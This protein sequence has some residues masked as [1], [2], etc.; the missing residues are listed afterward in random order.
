MPDSVLVMKFGGTSVGSPESID[1]AA[2]L[3]REQARTVQGRCRRVRDV[4][5]D[6]TS[7]WPRLT[8]GARGEHSAVESNLSKLKGEALGGLRRSFCRASVSRKFAA[9]YRR[10]L[11]TSPASQREWLLLRERP[12]RSVDEAAPTGE[13]LSALL[14]SEVLLAAGVESEAVSGA[15]VI[16]TDAA[17]GGAV[18]NLAETA[19]RAESVLRPLLDDSKVPVVTGY[20]GS[21]RD[22]VR[23]TLGRGGSDYSA[24]ILAAALRAEELWIWTDVDGILS[25]DPSI[26]SD[27]RLQSEV[28]YNEAAE[29]AYNGAKVLHPPHTRA[30]R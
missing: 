1:R 20:N 15:D 7:C 3:I 18:P 24:A 13:L 5:S 9:A 11:R 21:T 22:G 25:C 14:M 28:T 17:F 19:T 16:V 10:S 12:Q 27:A 29:L 4:A 23:T 6:E 30:A 26:A 8:P 2:R